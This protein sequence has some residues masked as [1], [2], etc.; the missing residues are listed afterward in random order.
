MD[1]DFSNIL[2]IS[3]GT[4]ITYTLPLL[5]KALTDASPARNIELVW[6]VRHLENLAWIASELAYLKP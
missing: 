3:G 2:A 6:T 5:M 4:G 1:D